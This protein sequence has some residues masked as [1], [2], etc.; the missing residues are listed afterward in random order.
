MRVVAVVSSDP[1]EAQNCGYGVGLL[2]RG[3]IVC[4]RLQPEETLV[5][6][7]VLREPPRPPHARRRP[8]R[9]Q[10]APGDEDPPKVPGLHA[11]A[12]LPLRLGRAHRRWEEL[13]S[14]LRLPEAR[15][16]QGCGRG[17]R[18]PRQ[19]HGS[20]GA[21]QGAEGPVRG[22]QR[23]PQDRGAHHRHLH[24]RGPDRGHGQAAAGCSRAPR[25][26]PWSSRRRPTSSGSR[27][28]SCGRSREATA[29]PSAPSTSRPGASSPPTPG[30]DS[31]HYLSH[32]GAVHCSLSRGNPCAR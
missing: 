20:Q 30:P 16:P 26:S 2:A 6:R 10:R 21:P 22:D 11:H 8:A 18:A 17:P 9:V 15:R 27:G 7:L 3:D 12:H 29:W 28:G 32:S 14:H 4:E 23:G 1:G 5:D 13:W 24:P 31:P 25:A 19:T